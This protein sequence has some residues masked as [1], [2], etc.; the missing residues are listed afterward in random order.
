[1]R[2]HRYIE[3]LLNI[4]SAVK[5]LSTESLLLE[6]EFDRLEVANEYDSVSKLIDEL[7]ERIKGWIASNKTELT[8][9]QT[10]EASV[11]SKLT[12]SHLKEHERL[13]TPFAYRTCMVMV[14]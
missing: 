12:T 5:I 3:H 1:M 14:I 4:Q 8:V 6:E 2:K 9:H 11:Q 7:S 10:P 13:T